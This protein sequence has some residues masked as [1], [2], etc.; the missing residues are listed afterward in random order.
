MRQRMTAVLMIWI[1][2][3]SSCGAGQHGVQDALR[4][5]TELEERGGCGFLAHITAD[6]EERGYTFVLQASCGEADTS[7]AV[8][9]PESIAGITARV[10]ELDAALSFEGVT[11]DFGRMDDVLTSPLYLPWLLHACWVGGYV[12]CAGDDG[13]QNRVTYLWGSGEEELAVDTWFSEAVPVRAEVFRG[14][15]LLLSASLEGFTFGS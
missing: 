6:V 3:L 14:G 5:R 2:L 15:H 4:F 13:G 1:L 9:T 10:T 11:L 8:V 12:S 7:I